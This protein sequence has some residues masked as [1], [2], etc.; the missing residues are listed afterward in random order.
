[1]EWSYR[2]F[3]RLLGRVK[4]RSYVLDRRIPLRL[5]LAIVM[6]RG[7]WLTRGLLRTLFLQGSPRPV[8]LAPGVTLRNAAMVRFGRG[9]TLDRA[10]IV[11]GLSTQ[12]IEFGD[13]VAIGAFS[14]V[15]SSMLSH[16]GVGIKFGSNSSC[17]PYS[18]IGAGGMIVIGENVIMGQHVSFHAENHNFD[19]TDI[20]I[21]SQGVSRQGIVIEDDCWVGA[22]AVFLD[23][24][25]VGHGCVVGAAA[26]VR[27]KFPPNSIIVGVPAT[28]VRSRSADRSPA[29]ESPCVAVTEI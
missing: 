12:G 15:Q 16:L 11:D 5:L 3:E 8:F 17:G 21:R 13:N 20:P 2:F 26:V 7:T 25:H 23:G 1:M 24:A 19:R 22:N 9:V 27:G 6:R 28:V 18:F 10:V 29:K 4:G 14:T